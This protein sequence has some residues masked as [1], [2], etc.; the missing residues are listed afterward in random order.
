MFTYTGTEGNAPLSFLWYFSGSGMG[1]VRTRNPT[2]V[3]PTTGTYY[4]DLRVTDVDGDTNF[5]FMSNFITVTNAT[6]DLRPAASFTANATSIVAGQDVAFTYTG[7][8]GDGLVSYQWC[9]NDG[10]ANE[11]CLDPVH[12][13]STPG[14]FL[15]KLTVIDRDGDASTATSNVPI[16]V[17]ADAAPVAR[18]TKNATILMVSQSVQFN[19]AGN[20]GNAPAAFK[21]DF[22][23]G[24]A[25]SGSRDPCH[26]FSTWGMFTVTLEVTDRDGDKGTVVESA[27]VVVLPRVTPLAQ[28]SVLVTPSGQNQYVQFT[29]TGDQGHGIASYA[30]EFGDGSVSGEEDPVHIYSRPGEY[31][32]TLTVTDIFGNSA[33]ASRVVSISAA[34]PPLAEQQPAR[35]ESIYIPV[36]LLGLVLGAVASRMSATR[37]TTR[38]QA[39]AAHPPAADQAL[40]TGREQGVRDILDEIRALDARQP[41]AYF[42]NVVE[43]A[44]HVRKMVIRK[45]QIQKQA[46]T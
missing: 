14:S 25:G 36:I 45:T 23:D 3:Y 5:L 7:T 13:F 8:G 46:Y 6:P 28:F 32:V 22:G 16:A 35:Y 33:R 41:D 27:C 17:V 38:H 19:F 34:F 42:M 39:K 29:F 26:R 30:W 2:V 37:K 10:S 24:S 31:N 9:F 15:A 4:V 1:Y 18:F 43:T 21:W 20:E 12:R 11:T 40:V 44:D